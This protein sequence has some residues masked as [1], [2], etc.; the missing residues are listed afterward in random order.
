MKRICFALWLAC[1]GSVALADANSDSL[2]ETLTVVTDRGLTE[3][4]PL[5]EAFEAK[6]GKRIQLIRP[7][8]GV[9]Q[10]LEA[11][12]GRLEVDLY[13]TDDI[14]KLRDLR[15]AELTEPVLTPDLIGQFDLLSRDPENHWFATEVR[16]DG[17]VSQIFDAPSK[18]FGMALLITSHNV[19][20]ALDL[21][22]FLASEEAQRIERETL[23]F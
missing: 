19:N 17:R 7:R 9:Q 4:R 18:T 8:D 1:L 12:Y 23:G 20:G 6:S 14:D 22:Q 13:L 15:E 10:M 16:P 3:V 11:Q 2:A 5:I 21:M